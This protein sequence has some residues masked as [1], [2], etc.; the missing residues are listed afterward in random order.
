LAESST[1]AAPA[2][3]QIG[4]IDLTVP[5]AESV[6]AFYER[7]AGWTASPV[8]MGDHNDYCMLP[9]GADKPVGGICHALGANAAMPPVWM[10]YITVA[11]LEESMRRCAANG[12][13]IR[14][15]ERRIPGMGRFCV[16]EDPAG[17]IAALYQAE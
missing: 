4:W 3:G 14:V 6:R 15:P 17:A 7:V 8:G 5:N 12:G 9:A 2:I 16:I 1:P 10:V 13:K 11:D